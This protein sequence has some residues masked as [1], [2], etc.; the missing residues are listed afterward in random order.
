MKMHD[1]HICDF[2]VTAKKKQI[3]AVFLDLL[4]EFDRLCEQAG[5]TYWVVYGALIGAVR[6]KGFI[7]WDDDV[8]VIMPRE[9]FNKLQTLT[10]EQ[11]GAKEPYFL[12]NYTTDPSCIQS[13]IR[14]RRSDTTDIRDYDLSYIKHNP[15]VPVYNMGINLAV[16]PMDHLPKSEFMCRLQRT[17]AYTIRGITYRA[18]TPSGKNSLQHTVCLKVTKLFGALN[19]MKLMQWLYRICRKGRKDILQS[20][21]GLYPSPVRFPAADFDHTIRIPFEDITIPV[22]AGY[23]SFLRAIYGDYMQLPPV[24]N[25]VEAAHGGYTEPNLPYKEGLKKLLELE[26]VHS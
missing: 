1:E 14:F 2:L 9:D 5:L 16:F 25:R 22:P 11:F 12:Q 6:H 4:Q 21:D 7:P 15:D 17:A 26:T 10:Q 8:D 3:N 13:L 19:L 18:G 23:D 24:E 20:F